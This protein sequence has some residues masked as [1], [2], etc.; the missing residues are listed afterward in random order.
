MKNPGFTAVA[1]LT[2]ALGIG[3]TTAIFSAVY[4][5]VLQPLP[6]ARSVAADGRRRDLP[7]CAVRSV[8]RQ[9]HRRRRR[10]AGIRRVDARCDFSSFNLS[11]G[12]A[13]ERVIGARVTANYFD[14][15]GVRPL[16]GRTF[17]AAEDHAGQ[18]AASSC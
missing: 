17:T 3:G 1:I 6:L 13:P 4:A 7:G 9:L 2:L 14:V 18:R 15:M 11:D 16:L 8:R 5:V 10:R 12:T